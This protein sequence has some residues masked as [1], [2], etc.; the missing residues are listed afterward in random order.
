MVQPVHPAVDAY[1]SQQL[2]MCAG[3]SA[4]K[5]ATSSVDELRV[6]KENLPGLVLCHEFVLLLVSTRAVRVALFREGGCLE[7]VGFTLFG[8]QGVEQTLCGALPGS[9][10]GLAVRAQD[11]WDLVL[12]SAHEQC[13]SGHLEGGRCTSDERVDLGTLGSLVRVAVGTVSTTPAMD[14]L[15]K[16]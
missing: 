12:V 6:N 4:A 2:S 13:E 1:V 7:P 9:D 15:R 5:L 8:R 16:C 14:R 11:A 10:V 3:I